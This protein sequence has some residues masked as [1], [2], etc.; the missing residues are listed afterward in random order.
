MMAS[1]ETA[2]WVDR[3][4]RVRGRYAF[5]VDLSRTVWFRAGGRAD[6]VFRP[7]DVDDLAHFLASRPADVPV[8]VVGLGSNLLV[9][10]GGVE[11]VVVRLRQGFRD[12]RVRWEGERA[13][14]DVGAGALDMNVARHC[15][16]Q[17][18]DGLAF[19]SGIP[20]T[21][22]G[23]LRMNAGAYGHEMADVVVEVRALDGDGAMHTLAANALGYA[24]RHSS[25]PDGWILVSAVLAGRRGEPAAITRHM[26]EI[27][28]AREASQPIRAR[29]GGSTFTNPE[30]RKAWEL[31]DDAG[32]RGLARGGARISEQHCNFIVNA[33]GATASDIEG[34][35][36]E[37]RR[38][39]EQKSGHS[40]TWEIRRIGRHRRWPEE[41]G[42][43]EA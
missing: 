12:V 22:G 31:I 38:R 41:S 32:C 11:G 7:A 6:V 42:E 28:A 40:L 27:N 14:V 37:V 26:E 29:T 8:T 4:P 18:V 3:L 13:L 17:G 33:G 15:R 10:D 43:G 23:A 5:D 20:G 2:G 39:V 35:A 25:V 16:D 36:E 24:Y 19:L 21:I 30:G 1:S 9:R 34:L